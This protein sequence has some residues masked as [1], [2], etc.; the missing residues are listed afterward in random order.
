MPGAGDNPGPS[1]PSLD[2]PNVVD[3]MERS[4]AEFDTARQQQFY[5][6]LRLL[7]QPFF[8]VLLIPKLRGFSKLAQAD[9]KR[10]LQTLAT[11]RLE[12]LRMGFQAMKRLAL[13]TFYSSTGAAM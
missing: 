5:N 1:V 4:F 8:I 10:V 3:G 11:S 6:L 7:E 13:F 2:I 12:K 9:R